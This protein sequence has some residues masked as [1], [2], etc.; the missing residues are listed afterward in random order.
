MS[1]SNSEKSILAKLLASENIHIEHRKVPTAA[2]DLKNRSL[3]LP[4]WK[5]MSADLYD[6]LIGH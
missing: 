2:F 4:I 6:L 1:V 5:E 3:I